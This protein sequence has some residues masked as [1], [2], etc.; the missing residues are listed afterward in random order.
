MHR[1]NRDL[2]SIKGPVVAD[3]H[4]YFGK[5]TVRS[6][7]RLRSVTEDEEACRSFRPASRIDSRTNQLQHQVLSKFKIWPPD[8]SAFTSLPF[9]LG[10]FD[11]PRTA[12]AMKISHDSISELDGFVCIV[13]EQLLC[14]LMNTGVRKRP[15]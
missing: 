1:H 11:N 15:F 9:N 14:S 10:C 2:V 6:L 3:C 5:V 8:H 13:F 4:G 7:R 12:R